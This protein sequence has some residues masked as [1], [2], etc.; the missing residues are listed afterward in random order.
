MLNKAESGGENGKNEGE[1]ERMMTHRG[2]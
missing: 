1:G 2:E